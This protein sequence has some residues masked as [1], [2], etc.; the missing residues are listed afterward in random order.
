[1]AVKNDALTT[2]ANLKERLGIS[3]SG[4][5]TK[6]NN[7][8]D[9]CSS[10]FEHKVN[11]KIKVRNY[12]G[13]TNHA[14]NSIAYEQPLFIDREDIVPT[15]EGLKLYLPQYPLQRGGAND[16]TFE[17]A[18]LTNRTSSGETFSTSGFQE[19]EDWI[20]V[21]EGL[22]GEITLSSTPGTPFIDY[23]Q[24]IFRIKAS[25]GYQ[26]VPDDIEAAVLELCTDVYESRGNLTSERI[27]GWA[28][29]YSTPPPEKF[30]EITNPLV[31]DVIGKYKQWEV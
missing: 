23:G 12:D 1:M 18:Y 20:V 17:F 30:G 5:D 3:D 28:R 21:D 7:I 6:L 4:E 24:R 31:L 14:G 15:E 10:W 11:R 25:L 27:E 29:S 8:I 19:W 2:L 16:I 22:Y 9:R 26:T 13:A